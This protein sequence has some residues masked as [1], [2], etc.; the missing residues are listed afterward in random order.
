MM[1]L[2][3]RE[4]IFVTCV[5][6][7]FAIACAAMFRQSNL[8][9]A[10]IQADIATEQQTLA[11]LRQ[12]T[13]EIDTFKSRLTQAEQSLVSFESELPQRGKLTVVTD[14]IAKLAEEGSLAMQ[15]VHAVASSDASIA[16]VCS[17]AVR[18]PANADVASRE[19]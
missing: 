4:F 16:T 11:R 6:A 19:A 3:R 5:L 10:Q 7:A 15:D 1:K 9:R 17:R 12:T 2:G 8:Q 14:H 13:A 18:N